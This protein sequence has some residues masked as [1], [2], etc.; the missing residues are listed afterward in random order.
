MIVLFIGDIVGPRAAAWVA[1]RL[2]ELR[3]VYDVDVTIANAENSAA[4]GTGT[5]LRCVESLFANGVDVIT[6]GNHSWEGEDADPTLAHPRVLRPVNARPELPGRGVV[7][8]D[9]RGEAVTV[10]NIADVRALGADARDGA[11]APYQSWLDAPR[12]GTTIVDFHGD[13]VIE[14][15]VFAYAVD[16]EA[17]AVLGTHSHEPTLPLHILPRGTGLVTDVG[18]TGPQGGVQG[19][20]HRR[21]VEGLRFDGRYLAPPL[22]TPTEG[23]IAL[24]AVLLEIT[25]GRTTRL[26]RIDEQTADR[27][28]RAPM[29][30]RLPVAGAVATSR[31]G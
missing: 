15:Q 23:P 25:N 26:E 28:W 31:L 29:Q 11:T 14:K 27:P 18:M 3:D 10:L 12:R 1:Q 13:H 17:A 16:G 8:I 2:P 24:G 4:S 5:C 21:F 9:V 7:T 30:A 20:D 22:P 6:G 19:F